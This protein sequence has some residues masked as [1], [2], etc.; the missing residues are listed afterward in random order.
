M[1]KTFS[2][3]WGSDEYRATEQYQPYA[4]NIEAKAHRDFVWRELKTKYP[5][6]KI[7]RSVLRGQLRQYWSFGIPC[8]IVCDVYE[9]NAPHWVR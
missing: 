4:N 3:A 6:A 5:D 1:H 2:V 8:G 9:I 7:T